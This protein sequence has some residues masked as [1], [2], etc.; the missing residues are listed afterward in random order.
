MTAELV[1]ARVELAVGHLALAEDEGHGARR[2][3]RLGLETAVQKVGSRNGGRRVP[4]PDDLVALRRAQQ[5]ALPE[6]PLRLRGDA[7]EEHREVPGPAARRGLVQDVPVVAQQALELAALFEHR[8]RQVELRHSG[9]DVH[10]APGQAWQL[11]GPQGVQRH[12]QDLEHRRVR[13]AAL[14]RQ[15]VDQALERQV[16]VR[17]GAQRDLPHPLQM[18]DERRVPRQVAAQ[19]EGVDEE[20]EDPLQLGPGAAR[21][22]RA[23][24]QV[25]AA[26]QAGQQLL[27]CGHVRH[28]GG[29]AVE[30]SEGGELPGHL[31]RDPH[32][33][34]AAQ[35]AARLRPCM[36]RR[37]L[38]DRRRTGQMGL[39]PVELALRRLPFQPLPLPDRIVGVPDRQLRQ[40]RRGRPALQEGLIEGR[41]LAH[42]EAHGPA[43]ADH[44]VHRHHEHVLLR[45]DAQQ[46]DP[47]QRARGQMERPAGLLGRQPA[48]GLLADRARQGRQV[49]QRQRHR[50]GRVDHRERLA[51]AGR[52]RG[53]QAVVPAHH[54][55]QRPFEDRPGQIALQ[56]HGDGHVVGRAARLELIDE[57]EPLLPA[58]ERVGA[59]L[60]GHALDP[61]GQAR[62]A[63]LTQARQ[64][65][66]ELLAGAFRGHRFAHPASS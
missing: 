13:E 58:R 17:V 29:R 56:P 41:G 12:E 11:E 62:V 51:G 45:M 10:G 60:P 8:Q 44:V 3:R 19:G 40:D 64:E 59:H 18:L 24:H 63:L 53:A 27:E 7:L 33:D 16:L 23:H 66:P 48:R 34:L 46:R 42:Q 39:P 26:R 5:L 6:M 28:E 43:V 21:D 57:P 61:R 50:C 2:A 1:G 15:L 52:E 22:R 20:A 49:H 14:R 36:V 38:Q 47:D 55:V 31:R 4:L 35:V 30:S 32:R 9:V 65:R 37:Q 54:L 25:L